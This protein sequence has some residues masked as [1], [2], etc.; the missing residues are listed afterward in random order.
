[1]VTHLLKMKRA[2]DKHS[3]TT[4]IIMTYTQLI[5]SGKSILDS[6]GTSVS[7]WVK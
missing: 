7:E 2:A 4:E 6:C 3:L 5:R 1:V